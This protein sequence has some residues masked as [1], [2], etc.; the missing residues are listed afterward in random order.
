MT[1]NMRWSRSYGAGRWAKVC[2][3]CWA[4]HGCS[5]KTLPGRGRPRPGS[6]RA[7]KGQTKT[8]RLAPVCHKFAARTLTPYSLRWKR[9]RMARLPSRLCPRR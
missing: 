2:S 7:R 5:G 9:P 3:R 8:P 4:H 6:R 1:P